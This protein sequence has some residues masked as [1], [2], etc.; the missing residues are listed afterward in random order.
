MSVEY[1]AKGLI[2][3]L[4]PQANTT[5][6]PEYNILTPP[7]YAWIN[8]R[9][10]SRFGTIEERLVDYFGNVH[11]FLPQFAN[12]PIQSIAFACTGTSYLVGAEAEDRTL[13]QVT[14]E[15][16]GLP[17][18]SAATSVVHALNV[19]GA[20]KIGLVSPYMGALD[21]ACAPY[22]R[23]RGFDVAAKSNATGATHEFHPIYSLPSGSAQYALD[24]MTTMWTPSSC[25]APACRRSRPSPARPMSAA[26]RC[27][28]ACSP[29]SGPASPPP[30]AM[31]RTARTF[32]TGSRASTGKT[33]CT[34]GSG[35][36][37][38]GADA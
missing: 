24:E 37:G 38:G 33:A 36:R 3:V 23:A 18:M 26:R 4:T 1:A 10:T 8:A 9:M 13:A 11:S 30:A 29:S 15:S 7:G 6:E 32:S 16:G 5:V 17:A 14:K 20:K 25:W 35:R 2:G 12:A 19:L 22:W 34:P 27:S 28:P 31:S 21:E